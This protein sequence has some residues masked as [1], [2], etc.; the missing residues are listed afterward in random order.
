MYST[1]YLHGPRWQD[2]LNLVV[3]DV[4]NWEASLNQRDALLLARL[5]RCKAALSSF[6]AKTAIFDEWLCL[7]RHYFSP[8]IVFGVS[9]K[10]TRKCLTV[11]NVPRRHRG[12]FEALAWSVAL[13]SRGCRFLQ[14]RLHGSWILP[15]GGIPRERMKGVVWYLYDID[16]WSRAAGYNGQ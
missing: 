13:E 15:C 5:W 12:H 7:G 6:S 14:F 16:S 4:H 10:S 9:G 1:T 8:I 11:W 3:R 2:V